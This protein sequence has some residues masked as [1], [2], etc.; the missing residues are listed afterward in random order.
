MQD[1][2]DLLSHRVTMAA[3]RVQVAETLHRHSRFVADAAH[4]P[5]T[6][7]C[8]LKAQI[9]IALRET[10]PERVR[11]PLAQVC[12]SADRLSRRVQPLLALARNEPAA[13]GCWATRPTAAAWAWRSSARSPR[14]TARASRSGSP[15][16]RSA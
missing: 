3:G 4:Q 10:D 16:R 2:E 9:E 12:L 13:T 6:P 15:S 1:S 8:G 7:V 14:C 5:K 11:H